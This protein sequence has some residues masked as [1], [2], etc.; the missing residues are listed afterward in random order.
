M[1]RKVLGVVAWAFSTVIMIALWWVH[2]MGLWG[3]VVAA[4]T[5]SVFVAAV[6]VALAEGLLRLAEITSM[7]FDEKE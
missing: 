3:V 2:S 4:G 6:V 7:L 1:N 5:A